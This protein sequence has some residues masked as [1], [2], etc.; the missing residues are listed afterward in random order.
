[1]FS[2]NYY[3]CLNPYDFNSMSFIFGVRNGF[4]LIILFSYLKLDMNMT[5]PLI[6]VS[7][8]VGDP[9]SCIFTFLST[10]SWKILST[11][12]LKMSPSALGNGCSFAGYGFASGYSSIYICLVFQVHGVMPKMN[13]YL[14]D[15]LLI[16][17]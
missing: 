10:P 5:V 8:K 17:S 15:R 7:I 1:M 2:S 4:L 6:F 12:F 13:S 3:V 11:S 16:I 9:R 14:L